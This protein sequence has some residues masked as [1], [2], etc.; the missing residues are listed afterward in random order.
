MKDISHPP[1]A[2]LYLLLTNYRIV[3]SLKEGFNVIA[4]QCCSIQIFNGLMPKWKSG[5]CDIYFFFVLF[6]FD[7]LLTNL[8]LTL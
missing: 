3:F 5:K 8:C 1:P 6:S 4:G 7:L 2:V